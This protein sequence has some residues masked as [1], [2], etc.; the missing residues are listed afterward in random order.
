MDEDCTD[1]QHRGVHDG[2]AGCGRALALA[3]TA[4]TAV[5]RRERRIVV[6]V[7]SRESRRWW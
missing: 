6:V 3:T 2:G 4:E 7:E 5:R 1:W